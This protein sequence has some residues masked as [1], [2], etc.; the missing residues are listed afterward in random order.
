MRLS[1]GVFSMLLLA[2]HVVAQA[3][4]PRQSVCPAANGLGFTVW[5]GDSASGR[6]S[7]RALLRVGQRE[8][9]D[10]VWRFDIAER[11][12]SRP[13][14]FA[15]VG[16]G[17]SSAPTTTGMT[18]APESTRGSR[19]W[20][21]CAGVSIGMREPTLVLRGARGQVHLRADV[22]AL[23]RATRASRDTASQPRR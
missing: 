9:I 21:A 23:S 6:D 14:F 7:G 20:H 22:S 10:T 19:A 18:S 12:W 13:A 4:D 2:R 5:A 11:R 3:P 16:A 17:W 8:I 15:T 1:L